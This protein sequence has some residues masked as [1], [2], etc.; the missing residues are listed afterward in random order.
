MNSSTFVI[1]K[2]ETLKLALVGKILTRFEEAGFKIKYMEIR[3]KSR[4]WCRVQYE[5]L[6]EEVFEEVAKYMDGPMLGIVLEGFDAVARVRKMVGYYRPEESGQ[7][8]I[9][10]DFCHYPTPRNMIHAADSENQAAY[11]QSM[12]FSR[13]YDAQQN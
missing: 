5:S 12:F 7:G 8:T 3:R 4:D 13:D 9:R 11:E 6:S 1:L 2:P 10:F